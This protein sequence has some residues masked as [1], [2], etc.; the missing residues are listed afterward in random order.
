[1]IRGLILRVCLCLS[2]DGILKT[3]LLLL[4]STDLNETCYV[5]TLGQ[6]EGPLV[7]GILNF[8]FYTPVANAGILWNG[9][10][11]Q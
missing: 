9:A 3:Y 5:D 7:G 11:R 6:N 1:M 8:Y 10:V 4:F 2:V